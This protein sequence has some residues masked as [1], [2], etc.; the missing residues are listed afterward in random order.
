MVPRG[1]VRSMVKVS[2]S[3]RCSTVT[4]PPSLTLFRDMV[5]T[6]E[7]WVPRVAFWSPPV[8]CASL[9]ML[10]SFSATDPAP[11]K[12]SAME[13]GMD[14]EAPAPAVAMGP[15]KRAHSL[16]LAFPTFCTLRLMVGDTTP[17]GGSLSTSP[18]SMESRTPSTMLRACPATLLVSSASCTGARVRLLNPFTTARL[19]AGEMGASPACRLPTTEPKTPIVVLRV[20]CVTSSGTP[21]TLCMVCA[22]HSMADPVPTILFIE[23]FTRE[24]SCCRCAASLLEV[25]LSA[26]TDISRRRR[27]S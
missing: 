7:P 5:T 16:L 12:A 3:E 17:S 25:A 18:E 8:A 20:P 26:P 15:W 4:S 21:T 2:G 10:T 22:A 13:G 24:A 14:T 9:A 6:G 19:D 11:C 23:S 1:G 27:R